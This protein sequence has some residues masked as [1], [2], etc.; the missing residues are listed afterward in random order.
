[1][2]EKYGDIKI[3][4]GSEEDVEQHEQQDYVDTARENVGFKQVLKEL[5][6]GLTSELD[7]ISSS[8]PDKVELSFELDFSE[9]IGWYFAGLDSKQ[10]INVK[11]T[12]NRSQND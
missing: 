6:K 2:Y 10:K 8:K 3:F 11:F 4:I 5:S 9:K 12:W 1:M 7:D